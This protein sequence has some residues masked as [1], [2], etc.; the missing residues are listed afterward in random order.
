M[1]SMSINLGGK[2]YK[3]VSKPMARKA[4]NNGKEIL[5]CPCKLSPDGIWRVSVTV[6]NKSG[7]TFDHSSNAYE[8]Y[9]CNAEA[10]Y[11]ASFY[12]KA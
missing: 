1:K 9:N 10:G 12:I 7:E 2:L 4:Y 3:R 6:S 11:Y 5:L 8:Y